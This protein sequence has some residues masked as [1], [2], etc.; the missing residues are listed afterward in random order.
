MSQLFI[1]YINSYFVL[2]NQLNVKIIVLYQLQQSRLLVNLLTQR[3]YWVIQ[4]T[5]IDAFVVKN[6]LTSTFQLW[7]A[8][9]LR[10]STL[11]WQIATLNSQASNI[12]NFLLMIFFK[13]GIKILNILLLDQT[14]LQILQ[15]LLSKTQESKYPAILLTILLSQQ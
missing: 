10:Q 12:N 13:M 11:F 9:S 1:I 6:M 4:Q 3:T 15:Q 7:N 2:E 5:Q 14:I 8:T